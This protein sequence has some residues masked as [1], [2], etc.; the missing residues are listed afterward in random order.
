MRRK[1]LITFLLFLLTLEILL[2]FY[3]QTSN[4]KLNSWSA[5]LRYTFSP[6]TKTTTNPQRTRVIIVA[7]G[8]S[9]S[10]FLAA[11]FNSHPDFF[12]IFEPLNIVQRLVDRLSKDY[13]YKAEH[14]VN[15]I[16]NCNF[17]DD[18]FLQGLSRYSIHRAS[19]RPLVSP[20]F[21]KTRYRRASDF[22][23][24]ANWKL[25]GNGTILASVLNELCGKHR[26]IATKIL[27]E[28]IEPV[29]LTW[30][31]DNN[32]SSSVNVLYLVRDPRAML[33]SRSRMGWVVPNE[34]FKQGLRNGEV[35][36]EVRKV[37]DTMELNLGAVLLEPQNIKLIRYEELA[38]NP[39]AIVRDLFSELRISTSTDVFQWIHNKTHV[40][41]PVKI[42]SLSLMRQANVSINGWRA[43]I[44]RQYLQII[45]TRCARV[46]KYLGYIPTQGSQGILHNLSRPLY[47]KKMRDLKET[48]QWLAL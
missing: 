46:L 32:G 33:H 3:I 15:S 11:V 6:T 25:C 1:T 41:G 10:S 14:A 21:C 44:D 36:E 27:L 19:S 12:F 39:E 37:C 29:D 7:H 47:L 17:T 5:T 18:A 22:L 48:Y 35:D 13:L 24:R 40:H 4:V 26:H 42:S 43:K 8:R 20:P 34:R 38:T 16:L 28:R 2:F 31:V 23:S 30:L 45:E 9:G